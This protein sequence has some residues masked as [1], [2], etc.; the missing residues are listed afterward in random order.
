ME[1]T[2]IIDDGIALVTV[3]DNW[4]TQ[5]QITTLW[6]LT[7]QLPWKSQTYHFPSNSKEFRGVSDRNAVT[8]GGERFVLTNRT[9][10]DVVPKR[11]VYSFSDDN[12]GKHEYSGQNLESDAWDSSPVGQEWMRI[13]DRLE[14]ELGVHFNSLLLNY[15]PDG[16]A[17]ITNHFD[18]VKINGKTCAMETMVVGIS[19]GATRKFVFVPKLNVR[20]CEEK[21]TLQVKSGQLMMMGEG[22]QKRYLHGIPY[23]KSIKEPRISATFRVLPI[24]V[25]K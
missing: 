2:T 9:S 22:V 14:S 5:Y 10:G 12:I 13:R 3:T 25:W 8:G 23:E 7:I 16:N 17:A 15:Y 19:L 24:S 18:T 1:T 11:T 4:L 20:G 21:K 6:D